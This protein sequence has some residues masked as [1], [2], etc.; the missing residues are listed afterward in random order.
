MR[1]YVF[2]AKAPIEN[3]DAARE[4][5]L[6]AHRYRNTLTEQVGR[7]LQQAICAKLAFSEKKSDELNDEKLSRMRAARAACNVYWGTYLGVED[8]FNRAL[9]TA[10][11]DLRFQRWDGSGHLG[12]QVQTTRPLSVEGLLLGMDTRVRLTGTGKHRIL[13]LRVGTEGTSPIFATF[14]IVYHRDLPPG[15]QVIWVK[16]I[17]QRVATHTK[18]SAHFI[19]K[20]VETTRPLPTGTGE[21]AIDVG[22]RLRP[23][24]SVR[25]AV[26]QDGDGQA[27][28][29]C[30]PKLLRN[31]D[32]KVED[33]RS[34]RDKM[35]NAAR[36]ELGKKRKECSPNWPEW[37]LEATETLYAWR[38]P[39]RLAQLT[40]RW[41]A[42][43]EK[44]SGV[45]LDQAPGG[46]PTLSTLETWRKQDKHL[47]EWECHQRQS[48][49]RQRREIYRLFALQMARYKYVTVEALD[50]HDFA[51]LDKAA[52]DIEA[53]RGRR[54]DAALSVLLGCIEG[55][56]VR[57]G[58]HYY[59]APPEWTTQTCNAC[60]QREEFDK[61]KELVHTCGHCGVT[62]DQDEN[63]AR[64]LLAR[65][66]T[67]RAS[68]GG[69]SQMEGRPIVKES[70][71]SQ[72]RREG[73][74]KKK[75]AR[76]QTRV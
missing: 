48:I 1:T 28:E 30:L 9:G 7:P 51:E 18:W 2:G 53:V 54:F 8:A 49:L 36:V 70:A 43:V 19:C 42:E 59:R 37:L 73:K 57:A 55:A 14:P 16:V 29:L 64:N 40:L 12:V 32:T 35:F 46:H 24:G 11:R 45:R 71:V 72:R 21:V 56:T 25:V 74:Q 23:N 31:R 76:S 5:M 44:E 22:W 39:A 66:A 68:T 33:L 50:L 47:Y 15:A 34:I 4:Q 17:T 13:H 67:W 65:A 75:E 27:G 26:W 10:R 52:S 61:K 69:R 3:A 63:A 60:G 6:L 58:G 41:R 62:W 20:G 38:S